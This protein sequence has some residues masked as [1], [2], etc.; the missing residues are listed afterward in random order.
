MRLSG[1]PRLTPTETLGGT[2]GIMMKNSAQGDYS[3]V[4]WK[5]SLSEAY[6]AG[7]GIVPS[8]KSMTC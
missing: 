2:E 3:H 6:P 1:A 4:E 8:D 7:T 5:K